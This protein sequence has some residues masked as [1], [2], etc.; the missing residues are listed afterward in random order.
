VTNN[1]PANLLYK[2][3]FRY[4]PEEL[5]SMAIVTLNSKAHEVEMIMAIPGM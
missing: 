5:E 2:L 4:K 3:H 1:F